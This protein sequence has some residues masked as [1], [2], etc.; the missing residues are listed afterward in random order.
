[1]AFQRIEIGEIREVAQQYDRD[2]DLSGFGPAVAPVEGYGVLGLDVHVAQVGDDPQYRDAAELFQHPA[3]LV[4]KAEVAPELVDEDAFN[5]TPLPLFEQLHGPIHRG[6]HAS[7]VDIGH[8]EHVRPGMGRHRHVHEVRVAQVQ[9]ADAPGAFEHDGVVAGR[10]PVISRAYLAPQRLPLGPGAEKLGGGAVPDGPAVEDHLA[11]LVGVGFQ[12]QRIHVRVALHACGFGLYDLRP[13]HF[14]A[15]GRHEGVQGHVLGFERR[16]VVSVLPENAAESRSEQALAHV[17]AR[18]G[19]HDRVQSES[20]GRLAFAV[21]GVNVGIAFIHGTILFLIFVFSKPRCP[22]NRKYRPF[23]T[24]AAEKIPHWPFTASCR[25]V[26][27]RW[28]R[29]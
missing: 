1:M 11:D 16:G 12:Q 17:A 15:V 26:S 27:M 19:E 6:E 13:A 7:A 20:G 10:Q 14:A 28:S 2:V 5:Q 3:A 8:Q 18:S 23:S 21:S 29:C 22:W 24:G 25:R 4:E 9:F